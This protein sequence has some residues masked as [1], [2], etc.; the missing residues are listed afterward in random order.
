MSNKFISVI[1]L[2]N[3]S[4]KLILSRSTISPSEAAA[5]YH[6]RIK[7]IEAGHNISD[8]LP[9]VPVDSVST[10]DENILGRDDKIVPDELYTT[11]LD[12]DFVKKVKRPLGYHK[13]LLLNKTNLQVSKIQVGLTDE[14]STK[15]VKS[16]TLRW[17]PYPDYD[18]SEERALQRKCPERIHHIIRLRHYHEMKNKPLSYSSESVPSSCECHA[19]NWS[20]SY[21]EWEKWKQ[22]QCKPGFLNLEY[23]LN[24]EG[25]RFR[26]G[27][28]PQWYKDEQANNAQ[29][30]ED[31]DVSSQE[32]RMKSPSRRKYKK[33]LSER[34][35]K[36]QQPRSYPHQKMVYNPQPNMGYPPPEMVQPPQ[37]MGY[38][39]QHIGYPQQA[40]GY[41]Q[42]AMGYPPQH[43]GY[44]PL[45][46]PQSMK[47]NP[48]NQPAGVDPLA[49]EKL[50]ELHKDI[51]E[52]KE[53]KTVSLWEQYLQ[54]KEKF[55]PLQSKSHKG[56]SL[57]NNYSTIR[58]LNNK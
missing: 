16:T 36:G 26:K 42:P 49:Y 58:Y 21:D 8:S 37:A 14:T 54:L 10:L 48:P 40:M 56:I 13:Q 41:P 50:E 17:T 12:P 29:S 53:R 3:L 57:E 52:L 51:K 11:T 34:Q 45:Y 32:N 28:E 44:P 9:D 47:Y 18:S 25:T 27:H 39:P 46:Y 19:G 31:E 35:V 23:G 20:Q 43:M 22:K 7:L 1:F 38:A 33:N 30:M 5:E 4:D 24:Q 6:R 15:Q 55:E 2:V